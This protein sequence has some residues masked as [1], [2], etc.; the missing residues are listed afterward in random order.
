MGVFGSLVSNISGVFMQDL[1]SQQTDK[2]SIIFLKDVTFVAL[3]A[4][5]EYMYRGEVNISEDQ[6][7]SFLQ[8]TEAL[9]IRGEFFIM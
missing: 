4:I 1:L 5:V 9:N 7:L 8:T 2:Q 3:K 6:L